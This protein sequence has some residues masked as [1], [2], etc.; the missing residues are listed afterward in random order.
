MPVSDIVRDVLEVSENE[1]AKVCA[2][3]PIVA[4][5]VFTR[6]LVARS[7]RVLRLARNRRSRC[8]IADKNH[9]RC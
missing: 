1:L 3:P 5:H 6:L 7:V 2:I 8:H 4:I 9:P